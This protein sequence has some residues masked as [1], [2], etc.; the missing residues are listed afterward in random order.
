MF[1]VFQISCL[2]TPAEERG[3]IGSK[4]FTKI[5]VAPGF[6]KCLFS[7]PTS[8]NPKRH[9]E[10]LGTCEIKLAGFFAEGIRFTS[11]RFPFG[12][13]IFQNTKITFR[14]N[15][16][17]LRRATV[18]LSN[19][20]SK[21]SQYQ[22]SLPICHSDLSRQQSALPEYHDRQSC[23]AIWRKAGCFRRRFDRTK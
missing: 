20:H 22:S 19:H 12:G 23:P 2:L 21:R 18:G 15:E 7:R 6:E 8:M 17:N 16:V 1:D 4:K 3:K 11:S 9:P 13:A 10:S 14:C 5:L